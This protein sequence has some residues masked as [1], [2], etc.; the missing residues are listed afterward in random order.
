M[1]QTVIYNIDELELQETPAFQVME[2][3]TFLGWLQLCKE[4]DVGKVFRIQKQMQLVEHFIKAEPRIQ[5]VKSA[6]SDVKEF[7]QEDKEKS[8]PSGEMIVSE[9]LAHI[10]RQQKKYQL[11]IDTYKK[12]SLVNPEKNTYFARLIKEVEKESEKI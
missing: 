3:N 2:E 4:G 5:P 7:I 6:L 1:P 12:L 8:L 9:T 11:S 10:Y